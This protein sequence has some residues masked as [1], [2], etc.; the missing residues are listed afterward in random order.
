MRRIIVFTKE[1]VPG[2]VKTRLCPPLT[3]DQACGLYRAFA[4]DT[5]AAVLET[6]KTHV[7]IAWDGPDNPD[8]TWLHPDKP[9][10]FLQQGE[11][12]GQ[13][14]I[15]AFHRAFEAKAEKVLILGSDSPGL[16][17]KDFENAFESLNEKDVVL[18]PSE[19]GGYYLVGMKK[20]HPA[21]FQRISWSTDRAFKETLHIIKQEKLSLGLLEH[22]VDVDTFEDILR[23]NNHSNRERDPYMRRTK[24]ALKK[25]QQ[26]V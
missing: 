10:F 9:V 1:P 5:A 17:P 16:T 15:H 8:L 25:L 6:A 22:F 23:L 14:L 2:K 11:D 3:P 13:K 19:D 21:V 18:G 12:L 24:E 26:L 7:E 4:K 20:P